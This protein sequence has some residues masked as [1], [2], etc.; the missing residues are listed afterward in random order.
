MTL[1]STQALSLELAGERRDARQRAFIT[2]IIELHDDLT[3]IK[4]KT[5]CLSTVVITCDSEGKVCSK[6]VGIGV[7]NMSFVSLFCHIKRQ[8]MSQKA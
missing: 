3:S 4:M 7:K 8:H 1:F 5:Y 6:Q 2:T